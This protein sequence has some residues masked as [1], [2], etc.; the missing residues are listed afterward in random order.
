MNAWEHLFTEH[1]GQLPTCFVPAVGVT[2]DQ[3]HNNLHRLRA[4]KGEPIHTK[5]EE[6]K[7]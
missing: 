5:E 4:K 6:V 2:W 1:V 7:E 3:V